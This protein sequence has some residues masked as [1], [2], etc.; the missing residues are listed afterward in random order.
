MLRTEVTNSTE[1]RNCS[2]TC[3]ALS[4]SPASKTV[5]AKAFAGADMCG[6]AIVIKFLK[7]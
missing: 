5:F 6:V 1:V 4:G 2:A 3:F 7:V